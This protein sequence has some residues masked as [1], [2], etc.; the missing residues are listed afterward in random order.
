[1]NEYVN[2]SFIKDKH[3]F[4]VYSYILKMYSPREAVLKHFVLGLIYIVKKCWD[5]QRAFI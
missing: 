1:M 3:D 4:Y 5:L 2:D